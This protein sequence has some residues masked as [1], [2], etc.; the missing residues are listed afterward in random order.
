MRLEEEGYDHVLVFGY[1][2]GDRFGTVVEPLDRF[3]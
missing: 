2:D 1:D 3:A